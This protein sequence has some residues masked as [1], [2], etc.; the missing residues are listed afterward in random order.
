MR[1]N[2]QERRTT[3][4]LQAEINI[5]DFLFFFFQFF[6]DNFLHRCSKLFFGPQ[7]WYFVDLRANVFVFI[8]STKKW[9]LKLMYQ[10]NRGFQSFKIETQY[11]VCTKRSQQWFFFFFFLIFANYF[12]HG[13]SSI[14]WCFVILKIFRMVKAPTEVLKRIARFEYLSLPKFFAGQYSYGKEPIVKPS[15]LLIV[16]ICNYSR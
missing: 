3:Y 8:D 9:L 1:S 13:P 16:I 5:I 10:L 7:I 2:G 6:V 15:L 4:H 12:L 11:I 14:C